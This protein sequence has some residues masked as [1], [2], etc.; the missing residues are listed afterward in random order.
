[1]P[2]LKPGTIIPTDEEDTAIND[3]I[4]ADPDTYELSSEEFKQLRPV[5]RPKSENKKV[6]L[7]VRYSQEVVEYF[8]STG[9][10]WQTRMNEVLQEYIASHSH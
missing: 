9:K 6:L 3:G 4:V 8:K 5:G 10:G 1:M 2:K 7:S